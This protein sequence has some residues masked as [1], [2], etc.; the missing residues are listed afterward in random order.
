MGIEREL[1]EKLEPSYLIK[2]CESGELR[3]SRTA[4]YWFWPAVWRKI[5]EKKFSNEV[6]DESV[7]KRKQNKTGYAP[8]NLSGI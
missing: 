8:K 6:I 5:K 1:L 3:N 7:L 2:G 4:M